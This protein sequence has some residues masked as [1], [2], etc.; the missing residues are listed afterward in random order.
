[1]QGRDLDIHP[2]TLVETPERMGEAKQEILENKDV[3]HIIRSNLLVFCG[4]GALMVPGE[5]KQCYNILW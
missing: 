4:S 5:C 2:D 3:S 1:M